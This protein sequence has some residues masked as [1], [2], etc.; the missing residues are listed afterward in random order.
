MS[1]DERRRIDMTG[2]L[3]VAATEREPCAVADLEVEV[4]D[5]G[6]VRRADRADAI[7]A[8]DGSPTRTSMRTRCACT[9]STHA[10]SGIRCPTRTN[11]IIT[12]ATGGIV[13][14]YKVKITAPKG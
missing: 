2:R 6:A 9:D 10:P 12:T 3:P 13:V 7:A 5:P 4:G 8:I 11:W 1:D 14:S